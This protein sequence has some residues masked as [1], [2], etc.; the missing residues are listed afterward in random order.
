LPNPVLR[1]S[2]QQHT[3]K[4]LKGFLKG[5]KGTF[6]IVEKKRALYIED[7]PRYYAVVRGLRWNIDS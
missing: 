7:P 1:F 2:A 4:T 6:V 5:K 3:F